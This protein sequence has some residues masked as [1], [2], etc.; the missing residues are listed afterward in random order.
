MR[1]NKTLQPNDTDR[2]GAPDPAMAPMTPELR[3][4]IAFERLQELMRDMG[5]TE[6]V[7]VHEFVQ[8]VADPLKMGKKSIE[9]WFERKSI[10]AH[11]IFNVADL[12]GVQSDWIG[13]LRPQPDKAK[14]IG[15]A[16]LYRREVR[17]EERRQPAGQ[18]RTTG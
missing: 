16:G 14:A 15:G 3:S 5:W 10:P 13:G 1:R 17:R 2:L 11:M 12:L 8:G 9:Q 6:E 4:K 18:R 7:A